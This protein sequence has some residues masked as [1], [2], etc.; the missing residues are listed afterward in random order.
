MAKN[1]PLPA[2][3]LWFD[4]VECNMRG[5]RHVSVILLQLPAGYDTTADLTS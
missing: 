4:V 2:W 3:Y 5:R 1:V